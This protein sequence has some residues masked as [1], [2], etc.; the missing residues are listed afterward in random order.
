MT[1]A[2]KKEVTI[3][4]CRVECCDRQ[5]YAKGYCEPHYRR[6][7]KYGDPLGGKTL[8]GSPHQFLKDIQ[9]IETDECVIWPFHIQSTGYGQVRFRGANINA[10]RAAL[11][12][13][14]GV[15]PA[16]KHA[17]HEP[18]VCHN[19]ACVNPRHLRWA[20]PAENMQD[21][22]KDGTQPRPFGE[23][24]GSSKLTQEDVASIRGSKKRQKELAKEY[25]VSR[26]QISRIVRRERW[27]HV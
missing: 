14:T 5:T 24:Q 11:I 18:V 25:G 19:R 21:R 16:E 1:E 22:A 23:L 8:R 9:R 2:I 20:T 13:S 7:R 26:S 12:L 6:L 3:G 27:A 17:A 4:D 10:H 15:D